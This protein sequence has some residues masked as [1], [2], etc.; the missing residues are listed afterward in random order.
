MKEE[1]VLSR[2]VCPR[3]HG[4][5]RSDSDRLDCVSCNTSYPIRE[6]VACFAPQDPFYEAR[7]EAGS[8]NY[9][10]DER[11]LWNRLLLYLVS[12]HYLWHLR[13]YLDRPGTILDVACGGGTRYLT[14]KGVV[15]G[16]DI[17]FD[18]VKPLNGLYAKA[19]QASAFE[20]PYPDKTFDYIVSK[21]FFEHVSLDK[22]PTLLAEFSRLLKPR[23]RLVMLFDCDCTNPLWRW[24]KQYPDLFQTAFVENDGHYGL[25]LPS[26][27]LALLVQSGFRVLG[28]HAANKTSLVHLPML[29]WLQKYRGKSRTLDLILPVA[30][31]ISQRRLLNFV[32]TFGVTLWDDLIEAWLPLDRA[33]YLL[34]ACEK[35]S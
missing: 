28:Y 7:Y 13:R 27:T 33:R 6:G 30:K 15:A 20:V 26:Q 1:S 18:S 31:A 8:F 9:A 29:I 25:I 14:T 23:G 5:L 3:C 34:V 11:Y 19:I 17:S 22:K 32:Y 24:A 4:S 21:F 35:V 2:L 12:M 16:L 10:P